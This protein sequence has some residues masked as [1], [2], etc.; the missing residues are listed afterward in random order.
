MTNHSELP[1]D[2]PM[3]DTEELLRSV[4]K[5]P[6]S[7][8]PYLAESTTRS[9]LERSSKGPKEEDINE[10]MSDIPLRITRLL[11]D[12]A[13]LSRGGY[14]DN[15]DENWNRLQQVPDYLSYTTRYSHG[16]ET[17]SNRDD[18]CFNLGFDIGLGLSALTGTISEDNR[19]SKFLA[20]LTTAFS[21]DHFQRTHQTKSTG[22]SERDINSERQR[23][24]EKYGVEPTEYIDQLIRVENQGW[25]QIEGR[26]PL[27]PKAA[28]QEFLEK[29]VGAWFGKC[30]HVYD[31]LEQEWQTISEASTPG[32]KAK[33]ALRALRELEVA[34]RSS[35][36]T[37]AEIAKH[38]GKNP[39][40]YKGEVSTVLNRLSREGKR[41]DK[42]AY[43]TF[44]SEEIVQH[45]GGGWKSTDYGELLL[46]HVFE[47]RQDPIWIQV[48]AI[49]HSLP[50]SQERQYYG[51]DSEVLEE[52]V[53]QY[54]EA[55]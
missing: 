11:Y 5:R 6:T 12:I 35:P 13:I 55:N 24:L 28:T 44:K 38:L 52:G 40:R 20:G 33:E 9:I 45:Q 51:G 34:D 7:D 46:Y 30:S 42:E 19:A 22:S 17:A 23:L 37:S 29:R 15:F 36:K 27:P 2:V 32:M 54:Y 39:S 50:S 8:A 10:V 41:P 43:T 53:N 14:L 31:E 18:F 26:E 49:G 21:T 4:S 25:S 1:N 3:N 47:K 48:T 16:R